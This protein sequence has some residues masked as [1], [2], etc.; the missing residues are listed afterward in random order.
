[1]NFGPKYS[2]YPTP[3]S[4]TLY[5]KL[6]IRFM[7]LGLALLQFIPMDDMWN[8][9]LSVIFA[10][11]IGGANDIQDWFGVKIQGPVSAKDVTGIEDDSKSIKP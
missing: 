7:T 1:M 10:A 11:L 4:I 8:H 5:T 9:I 2:Q 6:F 3:S